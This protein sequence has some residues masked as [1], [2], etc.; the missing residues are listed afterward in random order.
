MFFGPSAP[1]RIGRSARSGCVI[2]RSGLPSPH[3]FGPSYGMPVVLA[4]EL[5]RLLAP[6]DAPDDL[7]VLARAR[8]RLAERLAVPA[9]DD[10]RARHAEPEREPAVRQVVERERV[11]R[12]RRRRARRDLHDAGAQPDALGVRADPRGGRER[13]GAPRLGRPHRVEAEPLRLLRERD[14]NGLGCAPQ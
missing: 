5:D 9:L 11:H 3:E 14:G 7:D 1:S 10:L 4:L 2:E 13:V 8:E 12:A 6:Q